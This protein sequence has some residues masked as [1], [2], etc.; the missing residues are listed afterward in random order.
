MAAV[1]TSA[2][3]WP[4]DLPTASLPFVFLSV[5]LSYCKRPSSSSW[6]P[7]LSCPVCLSLPP[8]LSFSFSETFFLYS[9]SAIFGCS[10][11]GFNFFTQLH[12]L[13]RW[14]QCF[15]PPSR[16][17]FLQYRFLSNII[18]LPLSTLLHSLWMIV[19]PKTWP[20]VCFVCTGCADAPFFSFL[21]SY[22]A[23]RNKK[24]KWSADRSDERYFCQQSHFAWPRGALVYRWRQRRW[25]ED[26]AAA[27]TT[28]FY[29]S[30][31]VASYTS[32]HRHLLLQCL[33]LKHK[34]WLLVVSSSWQCKLPT[35]KVVASEKGRHETLIPPNWRAN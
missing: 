28:T 11:F 21:S 9:S 4:I 6:S 15:P 20:P 2:S 34:H 8:S 17:A 30:I 31:K 27:A 32:A 16:F 25:D 35:C 18:F 23:L 12:F 33:H 13:F 14:K 5:F 19:Y 10:R 3:T 24:K 29:F 1:A 22:T 7:A 26:Q